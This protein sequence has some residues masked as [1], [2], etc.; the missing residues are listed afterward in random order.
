M[1]QK[2]KVIVKN[3]SYWYNISKFGGNNE[4]KFR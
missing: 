4:Y 3:Q 1:K 2:I